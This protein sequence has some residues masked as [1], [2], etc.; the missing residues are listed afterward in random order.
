MHN[1]GT[2]QSMSNFNNLFEF[3]DLQLHLKFKT[4]VARQAT[5]TAF[6]LYVDS[7]LSTSHIK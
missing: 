4:A 1:I 5:L 7:F 3:V 6:Y 2:I